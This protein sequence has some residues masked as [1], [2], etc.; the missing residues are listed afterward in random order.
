MH[1]H[2]VLI[3]HESTDTTN[4]QCRYKLQ[5][6]TLHGRNTE[7]C[8]TQLLYTLHTFRILTPLHLVHTRSCTTTPTDILCTT[9][10]RVCSTTS[11]LYWLPQWKQHHTSLE[12]THKFSRTFIRHMYIH[13]QYI[14]DILHTIRLLSLSLNSHQSLCSHNPLAPLNNPHRPFCSHYPLAPPT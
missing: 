1:I 9:S 5:L 4:T 3:V 2:C 7:Q 6:S 11:F 13:V 8:N 12:E 14:R 10:M